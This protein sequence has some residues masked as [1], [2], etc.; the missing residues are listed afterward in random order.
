MEAPGT[1]FC[2]PAYQCGAPGTANGGV[3]DRT[4]F[5][6]SGGEGRSS[7]EVTAAPAFNK[8]IALRVS[9]V[10]SYRLIGFCSDLLGMEFEL[11]PECSQQEPLPVPAPVQV[12]V[13]PLVFSPHG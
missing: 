13:E 2:T 7:G 1:S 10:F 4:G 9:R 11:C 6:F 8:T 3:G 5:G 12:Q